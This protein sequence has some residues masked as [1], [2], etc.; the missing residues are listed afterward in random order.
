MNRIKRVV[1]ALK[2]VRSRVWWIIGVPCGFVG[3]FLLDRHVATTALLFGMVAL[4]LTFPRD[5]SA[6]QADAQS[7]DFW[8][9]P[10]NG[11]PMDSPSGVDATG[12]SYGEDAFS[13]RV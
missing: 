5:G 8:I 12:Y 13:D 10:S 4:W 11:M 7:D 1:R 3:M 2:T 6:Q 9:N